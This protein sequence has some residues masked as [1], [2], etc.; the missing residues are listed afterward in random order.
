MIMYRE[1]GAWQAYVD[2][3]GLQPELRRH[4]YRQLITHRDSELLEVHG[5]EDT[6]SKVSDA[7]VARHQDLIIFSSPDGII[8]TLL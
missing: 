5:A 8:F 4:T 2:E 7:V 1:D 3:E 6:R